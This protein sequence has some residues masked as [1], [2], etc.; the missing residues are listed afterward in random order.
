MAADQSSQASASQHVDADSSRW[1]CMPRCSNWSSS[2]PSAELW[3]FHLD[4]DPAAELAEVLTAEA[5]RRV[6]LPNAPQV[7]R[8]R[9][10][11][12]DAYGWRMSLAS[13]P[14]SGSVPRRRRTSSGWRRSRVAA[15][16]RSPDGVQRG[17]IPG[18]R[19]IDRT[20]AGDRSQSR[21]GGGQPGDRE[22]TGRWHWFAL[23][24]SLV[25]M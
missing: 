17:A 14:E 23:D 11:C 22:L 4:A 2:L 7:S 16:R 9:R 10:W 24:D 3:G 1:P 25:L 15:G 13:V 18:I 5:A 8:G 12:R 19:R 6:A 21:S 20:D